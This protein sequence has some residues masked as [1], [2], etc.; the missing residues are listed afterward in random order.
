MSITS[1]YWKYFLVQ[2]A[3][4]LCYYLDAMG[5]LQFGNITSGRDFSLPEDPEGW[6][7][8]QLMYGRNTHYWGL[9]RSYTVP[10]KFVGDGAKILRRLYYLG[11][12]IEQP[13]SLVILKWDEEQGFFKLYFKGQLDLTQKRDA[14]ATD[15]TCNVMEGGILQLLKS[16]ENTV[17]QLPCDGSIPENVKVLADG[18]K[19]NDVF[20]YQILK[21]VSPY[22]GQQSLPCVFLGNDGDNIGVIHGD[23]NLENPYA[24]YTAKSANFVYTNISPS[25]VRIQGSISIKSDPAITNTGFYLFAVTSLAQARSS[26]GFSGIDHAVGLVRPQNPLPTDPAPFFAP[27]RSQVNVNG[28]ITYSFDESIS[29]AANE[30]LFIMFFNDFA[31]HPIQILGGTFDL[32]FS[33]R[34]PSSRVWGIPAPDVWKLIGQNLNALASTSDYPFNYAFTSLLLEEFRRFVLTS[35]DAARASTNPNYFQYYNQATLNP[36]NPNNDSFD[37]FASLGPVVK[38][39]LS[40]FFDSVNAILCAAVGNQIDSS[41]KDSI[42]LEAR[43]YVLNPDVIT[44]ELDQ[45]SNLVVSVDTDHLFNWLE[46]GYAPNDYDETSGKYEYNNTSQYQTTIKTLA[47]ILQIISKIRTDSYGFEFKRYNTQGGKSSTFNNNDNS[48]WFLNTDFSQSTKDFFAA[49]FTSAIQ[50]TASTA[51]TNIKLIPNLAYQSITYGTL[52]G[53][54]FI[55]GLDFSIFMFNRPTG[56][57]GSKTMAVAFTALLNGLAGDSAQIKMFVNGTVVQSWTQAITGVNTVFNG[58]YNNTQAWNQGDNIY[59]TVDTIRTCTVNITSFSLNVG[60]GYF[61]CTLGGPVSISAGSTQQLISLPVIT[62]QTVTIGAQVL[63]VVSYGFQYFR[64]LS[65]IQNPIFLWSLAVSGFV[66]GGTS[67]VVTFDLWKNGVN[68]GSFSHNGTTAQSSFN[69]TGAVDLSGLVDLNLYDTYWVTGSCGNMNAWVSGSEL[70]FLSENI[71]VYPLLR[72]KYSNV[73]GIPN[74]ETAFNIEDFTPAR[75]VKR[76]GPMLRSTLSMIGSGQLTFQTS[77]KNQFLSTTNDDDGIT[78]TENA[79]ID[80]HDLGDPLWLPMIFDFDTN[81]PMTAEEIFNFAA[82]G[83][84]K[85]PYKNKTFYGFPIQVTVKPNMHDSQ[86]WKLLASPLNNL[87][88]LIDLDWDGVISLQL[89]DAMIP[90]IC[91]L[92][93]VPLNYTKPDKYNT[94]TMDEDFFVNRI[95]DYIDKNNYFAPW[96][97]SDVISLQGQAAGLTPSTVTVYNGKGQPTGMSF[98]LADLV[99]TAVIA[100]QG[101]TQGD[102]PLAA[103]PEGKYYFVWTFGSGSGVASFISEGIHIKKFWPKTQLYEFSNKRNK[104]AVIFNG[105]VPYR[106]SKRF[107]SQINLYVPKSKFTSYVNEPQDITLLN[108]IAYDTYTVEVG[109]GSGMPDYDVRLFERIFDLDT[110]FI[111]GNQYTR[112]ADAA[113]ELKTFPGQPKSYPT[114]NIR[115]AKNEDGLTINTTAQIEGPQQAGYVLDAQ[116]FGLS[117]SGQ[118]LVQVDNS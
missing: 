84:I 108:A 77:D 15:F 62:A 7:D 45:V 115:K 28:Q 72:R 47:K 111:D 17:V 34:L 61:I 104:L 80:Y 82:N 58:V 98:N 99:T 73:S 27:V 33:S 46:S 49:I 71:L 88:D 37:Q 113:V 50:N 12:S 67:N 52:D 13:V 60:S 64:F 3:T 18:I 4:G 87:A 57:I 101:A 69:P 109:F 90:F 74:P 48:L 21:I 78:I 86:S 103:F 117:N 83:H 53:E 41:G 91:P 5:N 118:D 8:I 110:V 93:F 39:S 59:F 23:Q 2:T 30:N 25:V 76:N 1:Q 92:H 16:Y 100:P 19:F 22:P 89:M 107:F 29:L 38:I 79:D 70:L 75:V 55:N 96:Q 94:Y 36:Q 40:D 20:H 116:A 56:E 114:L 97:L 105:G 43:R 95:K 66:Q 10:L 32:S 63:Q 65:N 68:I 35:G 6:M 44:L 11:K 54:Y 14:V 31:D 26:G 24:D 112:E 42:F 9:N 51:N 85:F 106:P 81:V 102:I